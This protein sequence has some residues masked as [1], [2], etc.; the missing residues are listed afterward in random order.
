VDTLRLGAAVRALRIRRGL[1]QQ[2]LADSARVSRGTIW[3]VEPGHVEAMT[4]ETLTRVA[5]AL[6]LRLDLV[7]R[8]RGGEL[9][10]LLNAGHSAMHEQLARL[11]RTR[12]SWLFAPEVS[13]S[14]YGERG[15]MD[16]LAFHPA[17]RAL[18]VIELKTEI[19]DVQQ[20]LGTV[21]RY[22]RLAIRIAAERGWR[23]DKASCWVILR[24]TMTNRRRVAAHAAVLR[25]AFPRDGRVMRAWLHDPIFEARGLSF[26]SDAHPGGVR[27][28]GRG[29]R[30]V[31]R[32]FGEIAPAGA[33]R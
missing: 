3:R 4:L 28:K 17:R 8:W 30:R 25:A 13:F 18:L 15:I 31:R 33:S 11:L 19:A 5:A 23:A 7:P 22:L 10:R 2:D 1:R 6:E 14:V 32:P 20:M 26:L 27:A 12:P 24:D 21:D 16:I 9:D 29:V